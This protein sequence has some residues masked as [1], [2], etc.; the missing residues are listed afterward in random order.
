MDKNPLNDIISRTCLDKSFREAFLRDPAGVLRNAGIQ[1][2]ES[3]TVKVIENTDDCIH[4]AIPTRLDDEPGAWTC[5]DR[6]APGEEVVSDNLTLRWDEDGLA[7]A[8]R[9]SS[10]NVQVFRQELEKARCDL[11]IDFAGVSFVGSAALGVLL[12]AQKRLSA[13]G[14]QLYLCNVTPPIKSVFSISG[15][16]PLFSFVSKDVK[17]E[18]W[19]ACPV[20]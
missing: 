19:M 1:V 11:L 18:W 20:I 13:T 7:L 5:D 9:V 3:I 12:S 2:P 15:L 10:E 8:G 17:H 16:E 4:V 6:P 14:K